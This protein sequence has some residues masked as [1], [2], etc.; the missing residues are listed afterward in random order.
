MKE[1]TWWRISQ[2]GLQ[3]FGMAEMVNGRLVVGTFSADDL[4]DAFDEYMAELDDE[5]SV[6]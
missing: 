6:N 3:T 1:R 4:C 5:D 2:G